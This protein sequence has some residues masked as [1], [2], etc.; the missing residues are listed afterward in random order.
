MAAPPITIGEL[1]NVPAPDSPLAAQWAQDVSSRIVQRF[2]N[3]AALNTWAAP[4]GAHAVTLDNGVLWRRI[5]TG[6]TQVTP[7]TGQ[8]GGVAVNGVA[9]TYQ[10]ASLTIPT[11][12]GPRIAHVSCVLRVDVFSSTTAYVHLVV[13][14]GWVGEWTIRNT[15]ALTPDTTN[16]TWNVV[17]TASTPLPVNKAVIVKVEMAHNGAG[18]AGNAIT[19]AEAYRNRLD[20]LVTPRGY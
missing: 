4:T 11:D 15:V 20:V 13:D 2:A 17:L 14:G 10:I 16:M 7:W 18:P 3:K 8:A 12:P 1:S 19:Y 5:S 9:A 6:W